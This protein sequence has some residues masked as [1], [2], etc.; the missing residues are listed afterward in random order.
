MALKKGKKKYIL[1]TLELQKN[2]NRPLEKSSVNWEN[3]ILTFHLCKSL[4]AFKEIR[5]EH[6][7]LGEQ[8]WDSTLD[9]K[10]P[11]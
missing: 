1:L 2:S 10:T 5:V 4:F 9:G 8:N 11:A 7:F 3:I 6:V